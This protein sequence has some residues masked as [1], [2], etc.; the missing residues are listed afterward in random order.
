MFRPVRMRRLNLLVLEKDVQTVTEGLAELGVM[1]ITQARQKE[2]E[3]LLESPDVGPRLERC[4]QVRRRLEEFA[5]QLELRLDPRA[6]ADFHTPFHLEEVGSHLETIRRQLRRVEQSSARAREHIPELQAMLLELEPFRTVPLPLQELENFNFLHFAT[7]S[8]P[9]REVSPVTEKVGDRSIILPLRSVGGRE[10][11]VAVSS[12]KSRWALETTL[13]QHGF[14]PEPLAENQEGLALEVAE[15]LEKQLDQARRATENAAG[16]RQALR[17]ELGDNV[18]QLWRRTRIEERILEAQQRFG[19]TSSTFAISGWVPK[20]DAEEVRGRVQELTHGRVLIEEQ[21]AEELLARGEEVP[22]LMRHHWL[23]RPFQVLVTGYGFPRYNE[24]APT[25]FVAVSF[26]LMF[27]LMFG[28][29]GHGAV[30]AAGGFLIRRRAPSSKVK[31]FAFVLGTCGLSAILFGFLYGSYF[32]FEGPALWLR[33][34]ARI[35]TLFVT[36]LV[37]GMVMISLGLVIN[38]VNRFAERKFLEGVLS[39]Y[40]LAGFV[41]YWGAIGLGVRAFLQGAGAVTAPA[42]LLF[43][44]LPLVLLVFRE[45]ARILLT[46]Q[47]AKAGGFFESLLE[48]MVEVVEVVV[49]FVANTTSF[50]RVGAFALTHAL[51]CLATFAVADALKTAFGGPLLAAGMIVLGNIFIILLEGLVV[52]IQS[53]RLEYYEFFGKFFSGDGQAFQPLNIGSEE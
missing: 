42:V 21:T 44:V 34:M 33:P 36:V 39:Q 50:L 46:R 8:L 31:D 13:K 48:G 32:G 19:R 14:R 10:K 49:G 4:R 7:G 41:F 28:D 6:P 30:L 17:Q 24:V 35:D 18:N 5:Q 23:L 12:K 20:P 16:A 53:V 29:V 27:G 1:H 38:M 25:L 37:L 47:P 45:P 2:T 40:G 26:L 52:T 15:G 51:L 11:L 3:G 22:T 43:I 9:E